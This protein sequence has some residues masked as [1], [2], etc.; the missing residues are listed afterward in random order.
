MELNE[1]YRLVGFKAFLEKDEDAERHLFHE[2]GHEWLGL[3][4]G[5]KMVGFQLQPGAVTRVRMSGIERRELAMPVGVSLKDVLT[6]AQATR[7]F[8]EHS[9][10]SRQRRPVPLPEW[11]DVWRVLPA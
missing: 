6:S 4:C 5:A 11:E 2:C 10:A 9:T 1:T 7:A 3:E 8:S